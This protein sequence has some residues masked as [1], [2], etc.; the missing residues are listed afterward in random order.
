MSKKEK[1]KSH[2]ANDWEPDLDASYHVPVL[3]KEAVESLQIKSDGIYVD[4]TFG[5]GGHAKA[6]LQNLSSAGKLVAFDQ[7]ED[8]KRNLPK[9]DR[10]I[11]I[12]ENFRHLQRF[13]RLH[14][15]AGVDGILADLGVSSHQ[16]DEAER[17][18]SIRKNAELDMR[19]DR[20]QSLTAY[21]VVKTYPEEKLHKL[22]EQYGEVTNAKTLAR[23]IVQFRQSTSLKTIDAFKS[24]LS[25]IVKGNPHKYFAQVFQ[26]LRIEVNDELGALKELLQQS[27]NVLAPGGRIAV[28]T[29]H[30]LEDRIVKNF[31]KKGSFEEEDADPFT[32]KTTASELQVITKKPVTPT[33][34]EINSNPRARSAKLRVAEKLMMV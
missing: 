10:I 1:S 18:F 30:S 14:N 4:C 20:R 9:D 28:I 7:D 21:D 13:L 24:A 15:I 2:H 5:G 16:F 3:L 6:I 17:G 11:F 34:K 33:T 29:F 27:V 8:A 12:P 31:F 25:G 32:M 22:F 23:T 26:A 19:M